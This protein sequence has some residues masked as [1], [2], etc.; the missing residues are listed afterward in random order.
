[1][2]FL[3]PWLM[4]GFSRKKQTGPVDNPSTARNDRAMRREMLDVCGPEI[5]QGEAVDA[6]YEVFILVRKR[7]VRPRKWARITFTDQ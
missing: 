6:G 7:L 3:A 2:R 1:V 4:R 5:L